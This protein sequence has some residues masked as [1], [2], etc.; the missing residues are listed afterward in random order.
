MAKIS[1]IYNCFFKVDDAEYTFTGN[2]RNAS[3]YPT[4][5]DAKVFMR[6]SENPLSFFPRQYDTGLIYSHDVTIKRARLISRGAPGI[7]T[8]AETAGEIEIYIKT[9][10]GDLVMD[11]RGITF[12][13]WNEWTDVNLTIPCYDPDNIDKTLK[14]AFLS[15][16]IDRAKT[17]FYVD[18]YNIQSA[19]IGQKFTPEIQ[20]ELYAAGLYETNSTH[21]VKRIF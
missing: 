18:D 19:Y 10:D 17:S 3:F 11:R 1:G 4:G 2:D 20:L 12:V 9:F 16:V 21:T 14:N 6:C 5:S 13:N 8:K 15:F 7:V